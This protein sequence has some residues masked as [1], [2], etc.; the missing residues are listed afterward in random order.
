MHRL[1]G[2]LCHVFHLQDGA[3][4]A[5]QS[6][7]ILQDGGLQTSN[8]QHGHLP[9]RPAV[10]RPSEAVT[11]PPAQVTVVTTAAELQAASEAGAQ[12]IEI[13]AHL[14]LSDLKLWFSPGLPKVPGVDRGP[15]ALVYAYGG[16]RSMRVRPLPGLAALHYGAVD[17]Q[18]ACESTVRLTHRTA[19]PARSAGVLV[20][21]AV[22]LHWHDAPA[23]ALHSHQTACIRSMH[24]HKQLW[25]S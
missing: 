4:I 22:A 17:V 7:A 8:R 23:A 10:L 5:L 25:R 21:L 13:R 16:M 12:D 9:A 11:V 6:R 3:P 1:L 20:S 19:G 2:R 18:H 14:D 24:G 15:H